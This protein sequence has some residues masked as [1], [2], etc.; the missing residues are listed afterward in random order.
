MF[1]KFIVFENFGENEITGFAKNSCKNLTQKFSKFFSLK[2]FMQKSHS[3][4]AKF[5]TLV[6]KQYAMLENEVALNKSITP[7]LSINGTYV[8]FCRALEGVMAL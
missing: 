3:K 1:W 5:I 6:L 4:L 2:N 8:S 7:L